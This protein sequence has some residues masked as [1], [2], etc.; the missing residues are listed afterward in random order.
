MHFSFIITQFSFFTFTISHIILSFY[1]T[2]NISLPNL[3]SDF[4]CFPFW[5]WSVILISSIIQGV[6]EGLDW[7]LML[8]YTGQWWLHFL[9]LQAVSLLSPQCPLSYLLF[10]FLK[11]FTPLS[12]ARNTA[13]ACS[14]MI[15]E[16][17]PL[18]SL[19]CT[20][21]IRDFFFLLAVSGKQC[22]YFSLWHRDSHYCAS[23]KS[24]E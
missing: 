21:Q 16:T 11:N 5:F 15:W 4:I 9:Y 2:F 22:V 24:R 8:G 3:E 14:D 19:D 23:S 17:T 13:H 6:T 7:W 18:S 10:L 1:M 12:A 20:W